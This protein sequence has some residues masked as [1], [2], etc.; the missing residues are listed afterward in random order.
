MALIVIIDNDGYILC[1][2]NVMSSVDSAVLS[3]IILVVTLW[4]IIIIRPV[5]QNREIQA[6]RSS[7]ICRRLDVAPGLNSILPA[8]NPVCLTA[9]AQCQWQSRKRAYSTFIL[10]K[11]QQIKT[12]PWAPKNTLLDDISLEIGGLNLFQEIILLSVQSTVARIL[13]EK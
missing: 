12:H 7:M 2:Y 3:S 11:K 10:Q 9:I 13:Q 1:I 4:Y 8:L 6:Y 5:K